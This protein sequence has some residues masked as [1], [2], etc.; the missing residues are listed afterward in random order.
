MSM[1][2]PLGLCKELVREGRPTEDK[3][4]KGGKNIFV[5]INFFPLLT[6]KKFDSTG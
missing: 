3:K 5:Q 6:A 1:L 2:S 4:K